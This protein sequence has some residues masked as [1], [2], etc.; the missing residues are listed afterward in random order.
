MTDS[1]VSTAVLPGNIKS[2]PVIVVSSQS[3]DSSASTLTPAVSAVKRPTHATFHSTFSLRSLPPAAHFPPAVKP[4][5]TEAE[6]LPLFADSDDEQPLDSSLHD[7]ALKALTS[8][9]DLMAPKNR[10]S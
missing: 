10:Q 6:P 2:K 7:P 9:Y 3:A 1:G 5:S 4:S 8:I